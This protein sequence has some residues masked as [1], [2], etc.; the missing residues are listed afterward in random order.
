MIVEVQIINQ[1]KFYF[2]RKSA[3]TKNTI[4]FVV[5]QIKKVEKHNKNYNI[6][7]NV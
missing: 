2:I 6:L 7:I 1:A 3:L 5:I 4:K